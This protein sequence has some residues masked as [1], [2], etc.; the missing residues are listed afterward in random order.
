MHCLCNALRL[1]IQAR[2][3]DFRNWEAIRAWAASL[4]PALLKEPQPV[5]YILLVYINR[6]GK[7]MSFPHVWRSVVEIF[8]AG[9]RR[10]AS[11]I[12]V[13][14]E[15]RQKF[16]KHPT[17]TADLTKLTRARMMVRSLNSQM[18]RLQ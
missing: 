11:Q 7:W 8:G 17:P 3:G 6:I 2:P 15:T 18:E 14:H 9:I 13:F 5:H 10:Q 1:I 16:E 4:R 12:F